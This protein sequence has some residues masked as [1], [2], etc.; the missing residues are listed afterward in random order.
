MS[1]VAVSVDAVQAG[2]FR[3]W[4]LVVA[5][6]LL[7]LNGVFTATEIALVTA[8]RARIEEAG[9]HGDRRARGALRALSDLPTAFSATQL[10]ATMTSLGLGAVAEPALAALLLTVF[11]PLGWASGVSTI[12]AIG[13]ALTVVMFLH[14]VVGDMAPKN[15][16]IARA[17][18]VTLAVAAPFRGF[19]TVFRPLIALLELATRGVLLLLRVQ[20]V[21]QRD[22]A[23]TPEELSLVLAESRRRGT[24]PPTD[25]RTM[26]AALRLA[27]IDAGAA[28]TPRA[29]VVAIP[30]DASLGELL[31][32]AASTGFT[33]LPVYH[34][35]LDSVVGLVHVKD[36]LLASAGTDPGALVRPIVA[37]PESVDLEQLLPD[38][39]ED[40]HHL[41]LVVDEYG[42]TAGVLTLEDVLEELVGDIADEF[43]AQSMPRRRDARSW[44]VPGTLRRDELARLT[45]LRLEAD[46]LE[47]ETVSGWLVEQLGRLPRIGDAIEHEGWRLVVRSLD[48]LRAG[49]VHIEAP[50]AD[51]DG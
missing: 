27:E 30:D 9:A 40:R 47:T 24:I 50:T 2:A 22:L 10:G 45:G 8:R 25:A 35:S 12:V 14:M 16:A 5:V 48:G 34:G 1:V 13:L 28:M 33:R 41:V 39:L 4:A 18:A 32:T 3:P 20:P 36:A 26:D 38:L 43:D 15:L 21:A 11:E 23:H 46:D 17:E 37:V 42:A 44:D 51:A 7:A 31:D 6:G 49:D 19:V 29:D